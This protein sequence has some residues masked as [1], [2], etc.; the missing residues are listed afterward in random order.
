MSNPTPGTPPNVEQVEEI[1]GAGI[2]R[3]IRP[4]VLGALRG[5][6]VLMRVGST[7]SGLQNLIDAPRPL[8]LAAN[9]QSH[10]DTFMIREMLPG[11]MVRRTAVAAAFDYFSEQTTPSLKRR[12]LERT[13][14]A[15]FNAFGFDRHESSPRSMRTVVKLLRRDWNIL[16]FPEGTRSPDGLLREFKA[17]VGVLARLAKCPV[18]PIYVS[19][20]RDV[21]PLGAWFTHHGNMCVH[22]GE[23]MVY[24]R[25]ES[26]ESFTA[27]VQ[28][29]VAA[30]GARDQA[31]LRAA[32]AKKAT[33]S[34][35]PRTDDVPK[36]S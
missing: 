30:M 21:L 6:G 16:L 33:P 9:H 19:G 3:L 26:P 7:T 20:G 14:A 11:A 35:T 22:F 34:D 5:S 27:R 10:V 24:D 32:A 8:I 25:T 28:D 17:G 36:L 18:V 1:L 31:A 4:V 2:N 15:G 23:P 12:M 29:A 13:V